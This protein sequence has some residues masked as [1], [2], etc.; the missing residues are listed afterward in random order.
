MLTS[1]QRAQR[2]SDKLIDSIAIR[3]KNTQ[4]TYRIVIEGHTDSR[5][6]V[7]GGLFP[8]NWEL[9]GSRA[10]RVVRMFLEKGFAPNR[11]VAIGYADTQPEV[12]SRTPNGEWDETALA[13]NRRVVLRILEPLVDS[14][15]IAE[16]ASTH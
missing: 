3:Q 4:K 15:P 14:I 2:F 13:K 9:S 1:R 16:S 5:P 8:S 11:M 10:A 7:E 12:P 6:I